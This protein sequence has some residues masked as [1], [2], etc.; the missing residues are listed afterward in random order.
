MHI[1]NWSIGCAALLLA[2]CSGEAGE[3]PAAAEV[4]SAEASSPEVTISGEERRILAFGNSLFAGYGLA[5]AEGYPEQ[6]EAALRGQ[7]VNARVIDA[8]VSGDTSAAGR[9]R[10][11]FTLDGLETPPDLVL[12]ELG[13]NDIIRGLSPAETRAN[14]EAMLGE[15]RSRD[16]PVLIMGMRAPPNYGPEFQQ[17]FDALYSDLAREFD[18]ALV[19]FWLESIYQDPSLFQSDRIHPTA[20]GIEALVAATL[21][22]VRAALPVAE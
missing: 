15:L 19:P 17:S 11:A 8:G 18:A 21:D 4:A 22:D 6:L 20:P 3:A 9:Q 1:G 10:L 12:L 5:E 2:A 7:G 13:G 14:F 16:I